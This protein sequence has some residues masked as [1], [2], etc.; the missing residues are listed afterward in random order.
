[1]LWAENVQEA[2]KTLFPFIFITLEESTTVPVLTIWT[3]RLRRVF[4]WHAQDHSARK[5]RGQDSNLGLQ[6]P[7]GHSTVHRTVENPFV[8]TQGHDTRVCIMDGISEITKASGC[9]G[10]GEG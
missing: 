8:L 3:M 5:Q 6:I 9:L 7:P 1:M 10:I 4:K 2:L